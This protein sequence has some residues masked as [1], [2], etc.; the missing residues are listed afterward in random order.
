M[1]I[2]FFFTLPHISSN[3]HTT[4]FAY[5]FF[6]KNKEKLQFLT[7]INLTITSLGRTNFLYV[8]KIIKLKNK[9]HHNV[10]TKNRLVSVLRWIY[11]LYF[12]AFTRIDVIFSL[13]FLR[14]QNSHESEKKKILIYYFL[15][16]FVL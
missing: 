11:F 1:I 4:S 7:I 8:I 2:E 12:S 10:P 5:C 13:Y 16:L 3:F 9:N 15:C 6:L 14:L